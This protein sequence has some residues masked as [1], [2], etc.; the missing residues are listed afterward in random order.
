VNEVPRMTYVSH[1]PEHMSRVDAQTKALVRWGAVTLA[2]LI[3][4]SIVQ[5]KAVD[6][7]NMLNSVQSRNVFPGHA[8]VWVG[9]D[10]AHFVN[11]GHFTVG[12]K[13]YVEARPFFDHGLSLF[14]PIWAD[15]VRRLR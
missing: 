12:R 9:A 5:H 7:G 4:L 1:L 14:S 11:Y 3:K 15:A 13:S 10:Y 8:V 6:T 2:G